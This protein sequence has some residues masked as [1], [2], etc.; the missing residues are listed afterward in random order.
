[1]KKISAIILLM[2]MAVL[3]ASAQIGG[4]NGFEF[5]CLPYSS[6]AS[7]L[8][9]DNISLIED[10]ATLSIQNPALL[11][12]VSHNSVSLGYMRYM[13]GVSAFSANYA[14]AINDTATVGLVAQY[15]DYGKMKEVD[16][17]NNIL[18]DFGAA[19]LA[20][21]AQLSY[22]LGKKFV[23][24]VTAKFIYS[25]IGS[26]SSTAVA[27]DLGLNYYE[28]EKD[29]SASIVARNLGGQLSAYYEEYESLP[30]NVQA[31][32][33]KR[34]IGTPLRVSLTGSDLQHWNY[35]FFR[36]LTVGADLILGPQFY[37]AAGYNFRRAHEMSI[38]TLDS[39]GEED[40]S[41]HGAGL[42]VGAG[43]QLE[44]FKAH[45]SY[46][47]YHVSSSSL[48]FNIAFTL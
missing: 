29:F 2:T 31:G 48:L 5:L 44:R 13:E 4:G 33:T 25:H 21:G 35:S 14:Y 22:Y 9:G 20:I 36:H 8:G 10:D 34:L 38:T 7:A 30:V 6:H 41:A 1:M 19:D 18:G 47:K 27:V 46:A 16:A 43:L 45:V 17:Y 40:K 28:P 23:G 15:V 24:G 3:T 26:Y 37:I 32:V 12:S 39:W 11:Q 42:S